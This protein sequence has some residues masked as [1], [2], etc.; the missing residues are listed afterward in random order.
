MKFKKTQATLLSS[1][2]ITTGLFTGYNA[3][4]DKEAKAETVINVKDFGAIPNDGVDDTVALNKAFAKVSEGT[5]DK[6]VKLEAGIYETKDILK[7]ENANNV[8]L[9]GAGKDVTNIKLYTLKQVI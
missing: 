2:M 9:E 3:L 8:T 7:M 6:V 4:D 5:D 1:L